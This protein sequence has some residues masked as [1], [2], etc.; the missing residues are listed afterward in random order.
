MLLLCSVTYVCAK[1]RVVRLSNGSSEQPSTFH[2]T[3]T[4]QKEGVKFA[5]AHVNTGI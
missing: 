3:W 2:I 1:H 5:C 4:A